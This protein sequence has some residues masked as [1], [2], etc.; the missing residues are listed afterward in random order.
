MI[1]VQDAFTIL[2]N[3]LPALQQVDCPLIQARKHILAQDIF[4]PV[5]MPPFQ[6]S[7]MDGFALCLFDGLEYEII[8]EIKAGDSHQVNL[9]PGQAIKIFTGAAVPDS[10]QA[11]IQ[12]EKVTVKDAKLVL[13]EIVKPETNVRPLGEQIKVGELA[14]EKGTLLNAAAI[15]FLAGLGLT[16]AK[17]F[18]KPRLGIVVTGN[19]LVKP[20]Q[21]LEYGKVFESNGIMLESALRDA[22][23]ENINR[24]E[25]NDDFE[26]TKSK[27]Q[28]ALSENEVVLVSGGISVGD[29][30][31]VAHA[32]EELQVETLFHKIN[33]KPGK[34]LFAG[35]RED[36]IIFALPGNPAAALSCFYV[37]VLPTIKVISGE[38][39]NYN[40]SKTIAIAHDYSVL[41]T[42]AQF[43]KATF[44]NDEVSVLS[45]QASSMLN[46]FSVSNG[47]VFVPEG[48]Y[49][50]KKGDKVA[51]YLL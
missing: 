26:N 32:L 16:T 47:L 41:N 18:Q 35:K 12:I 25:V 38:A 45:H 19:E 15:G 28:T 2:Q 6:Q 23:F 42:R 31:F 4:S 37:Y 51:V 30:D 48:N 36:K 7:A 24:Y 43:L 46:S 10:A 40:Q 5:N 11:V 9:S 44:V 14:L 39:A 34:P 50:L 1:S 29:Y 49:E 13:E 27:L 20:G 8:G 17:V 21:P 3:N 22:F 33:Q